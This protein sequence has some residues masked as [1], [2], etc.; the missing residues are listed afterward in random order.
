[1]EAYSTTDDRKAPVRIEAADFMVEGLVHLPGMR[2]SDLVNEKY[3]FLAVVNAVLT[4]KTGEND[5]QP[6][7]YPTLLIRKGEIRYLYPLD[8]GP[9]RYHL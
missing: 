8:D 7:E 2:L 3:E 6:I 9:D 4:S 5:G 1:M